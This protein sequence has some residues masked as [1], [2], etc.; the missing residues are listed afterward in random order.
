MRSI[1]PP[2]LNAAVVT[3]RDDPVSSPLTNPAAPEQHGFSP[4]SPPQPSEPDLRRRLAA[5]LDAEQRRTI[6]RRGHRARTIVRNA[7]WSSAAQRC[8]A[9][10]AW[11]MRPAER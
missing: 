1:T 8:A 10:M 11:T 9:P 7:T 4:P 5:A 3:V 6:G 2:G